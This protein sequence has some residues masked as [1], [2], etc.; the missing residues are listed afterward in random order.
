M[1]STESSSTTK[2]TPKTPLPSEEIH[3]PG[4]HPARGIYGFALYI[5][6]WTL[7]VIYLIWAITPV[8]ILYRLGITYIPSKL[9]AL[10][11]GIFF[12]TAACLYVTVIFLINCWNFYGIFDNVQEVTND[13]GE[14]SKS[15]SIDSLSSSSTESPKKAKKC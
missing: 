8:P 5:V 4:P 10:A 7:F 15:N 6:S 3:L 1:T 9:W 2:K 12:P 14:R 11:I 13:F